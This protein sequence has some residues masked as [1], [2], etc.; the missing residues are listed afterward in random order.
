MQW[1]Q[2]EFIVTCDPEKQDL[3]VIHGFLSQSYW[4]K[5]IPKETVRRSICGS[6]C[7]GLLHKDRQVGFA[8]VISDLATIA[9]LGDVFVLDEYRGRG[10]SKWLMECVSA[11]PD[12]QGLRRWMLATSDAHGLYEKYGFTALSKPHLFME[13]HNPSIYTS[14]AEQVVATDRPKT[15]SG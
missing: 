13:R 1:T 4:A 8:R 6:L 9:Y 5:G 7:F 14:D 10:L 3:E 2:G 15:K 12:L 11:H